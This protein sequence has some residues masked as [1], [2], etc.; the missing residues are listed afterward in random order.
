MSG[1]LRM[2]RHTADIVQFPEGGKDGNRKPSVSEVEVERPQQP[3]L[4][5]REKDVKYINE[6]IEAAVESGLGWPFVANLI[7]DR[8]LIFDKILVDKFLCACPEDSIR[9]N[10]VN[11][12]AQSLHREF[13]R[14][15]GQFQGWHCA[16]AHRLLDFASFIL[17]N[18]IRYV[19]EVEELK[20]LYE[21][22][23]TLFPKSLEK[24]VTAKLDQMARNE[25]VR[26][27]CEES[28][29]PRRKKTAKPKP[30]LSPEQRAELKATRKERVAACRKERQAQKK[31][32]GKK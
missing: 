6:M 23:Q 26:K 31:G 13:S 18:D 12:F 27:P 16:N 28:V 11:E 22:H 9:E 17:C 21:S 1:Y 4:S 3:K 32:K 5:K 29:R 24:R 2:R 25:E 7:V 20:A 14:R 10:L 8:D 30:R 15:K 19:N